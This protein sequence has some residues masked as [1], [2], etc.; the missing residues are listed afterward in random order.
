[1][2]APIFLRAWSDYITL[3]LYPNRTHN[4]Q[5][6]FLKGTTNPR[7]M[8]RKHTYHSPPTHHQDPRFKSL[9]L[10]CCWLARRHSRFGLGFPGQGSNGYLLLLLRLVHANAAG[11]ARHC[12]RSGHVSKFP[13][14]AWRRWPMMRRAMEYWECRQQLADRCACKGALC[15]ARRSPAIPYR[16]QR[17]PR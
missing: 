3:C 13:A 1:M 5:N 4:V 11:C 15:T 17:F 7:Y 14:H 8:Y 6:L 12:R 2:F 16:R 9:D 10:R